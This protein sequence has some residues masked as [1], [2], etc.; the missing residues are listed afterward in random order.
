[1]LGE[2]IA[3]VLNVPLEST[4]KL[5]FVVFGLTEVTESFGAKGKVQLGCALGI[6]MVFG[7]LTQIADNGVPAVGLFAAWFGY[8]MYGLVIALIAAGIHDKFFARLKKS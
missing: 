6:G 2:I 1:M 3:L 4:L 8:I 5:F 7:T